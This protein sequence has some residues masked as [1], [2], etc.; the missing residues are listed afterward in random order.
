MAK[1]YAKVFYNSSDWRRAREYAWRRDFGLCVRC[2]NVGAV[3]HHKQHITPRNIDNPNVTLNPNNLETLC[4][5][6]HN[7]EHKGKPTTLSGLM[8]DTAGNLVPN[9]PL[10]EKAIYKIST[11]T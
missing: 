6:C 2:G 10:F 7:N 5:D 4:Y 3:V 9:P 1:E 8:F 11:P